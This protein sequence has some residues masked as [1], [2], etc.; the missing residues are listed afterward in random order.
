MM[1]HRSLLEALGHVEVE[2]PDPI[3]PELP[4]GDPPADPPL[5]GG[6][7]V[8]PPTEEEQAQADREHGSWLGE[9]FGPAEVEPSSSGSPTDPDAKRFISE[10]FGSE[11]G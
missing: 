1:K 3:A 9:N 6:R 11:S 7:E 8:T 2:Q 4:H 10:L 5:G